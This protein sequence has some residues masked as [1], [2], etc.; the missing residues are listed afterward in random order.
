[1]IL[2]LSKEKLSKLNSKLY[3]RKVLKGINRLFKI[4]K[5][6]KKKYQRLK[7]SLHCKDLRLTDQNLI[8]IKQIKYI[9]S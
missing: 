8:K 2:C 6:K 5:K 3:Y 4:K 7:V 9:N 1:M